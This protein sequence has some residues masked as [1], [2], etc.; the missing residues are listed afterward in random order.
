VP[1]IEAGATLLHNDADFEVL[2]R[3]SPL[4]LEPVA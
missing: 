2:A 4:R 3:H 1:V